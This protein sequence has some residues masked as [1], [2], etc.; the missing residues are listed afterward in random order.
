MQ[1]P[2]GR[3]GT[4]ALE[5]RKASHGLRLHINTGA[6]C[7]NNCLFCMESDR[8]GRLVRNSSIEP[9][10]VRALL[11]RH[12]GAEEAC[13]TSGEPTT[14]PHLA[15][16]A[17]WSRELG[18]RCISVMTNGRM[19]S[20]VPTT[21]R[22]IEAGINRFNVSI[23][24]HEAGLHE[25]LTRTPGSFGQTVR[26][27]AVIKALARRSGHQVE[28]HTS[29]VVNK[30]NLPH[31]TQI[32]CFLRERGVDQAVFNAMEATGRGQVHF[33]RLFPRYSDVVAG[34]RSLLDHATTI[35]HEP[36]ALAFLVDVPPCL[37]EKLPDFHRGFVE[38][39]THF[40]PL[41]EV[42]RL[43]EGGVPED[44]F[45]AGDLVKID[46]SDIDRAER[47]WHERCATC[48]RRPACDGVW[49]NYTARF[50]WDELQPVL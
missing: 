19:L 22:L 6:S 10:Q 21:R 33:E 41:C 11:E 27:L 14:N 1:E 49:V 5:E 45:V 4:G 34:F 42:T 35:L 13:F 28:L 50:G 23:H 29:T 46:R 15:D 31:L 24:G 37:T 9:Q 7:N 8:S 32:Y 18:Y 47:S 40:S 48:R 3:S 20:H 43:F 12:R 44:R 36:H 26:G 16:Y 30:R 39:H 17:A 2:V 25:S 38:R